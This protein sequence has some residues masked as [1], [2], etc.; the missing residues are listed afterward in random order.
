MEGKT[1]VFDNRRQLSG[2][3]GLRRTLFP[4]FVKRS[5]MPSAIFAS[6]L[7]L[8]AKFFR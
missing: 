4:F 1:V 8:P 7:P 2:E 5:P 3:S 6:L